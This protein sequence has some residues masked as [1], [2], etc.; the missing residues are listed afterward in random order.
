MGEWTLESAWLAYCGSPPAPGGAGWNWDPWLAAAAA[1]HRGPVDEA[2]WH[3]EQ[4]ITPREALACSVD[5]QR[6]APGARG[7]V[8]LVDEDPLAGHDLTSGEQAARLRATTV[9]VTVVDGQVV[10]GG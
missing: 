6:L 4:A 8:V 9:S 7:D 2:S 10:H 1:V 5:G 3:P